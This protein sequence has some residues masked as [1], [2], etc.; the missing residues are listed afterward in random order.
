MSEAESDWD[1]QWEEREAAKKN[2][3]LFT[4]RV[5]AQPLGDGLVRVNFGEVID[6]EPSYHTA[7]VITAANAVAFGELIYRMGIA[8]TPP[9]DEQATEAV[10]G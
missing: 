1:A 9:S 4:N 8:L 5:F 3:G 2:T 7:I 6:T 10:D